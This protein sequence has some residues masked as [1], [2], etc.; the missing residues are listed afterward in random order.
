MLVKHNEKV[1]IAR[2]LKFMDLG[3]QIAHDC[4]KAQASIAQ[5]LE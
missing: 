2:L 4:A 3:E 1:P 5:S